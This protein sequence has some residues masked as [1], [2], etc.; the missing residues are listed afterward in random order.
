M[1]VE[2]QESDYA[3][4]VFVP[5]RTSKYNPWGENYLY[6]FQYYT[7]QELMN[8][9]QDGVP[10]VEKKLKALY[11]SVGKLNTLIRELNEQN[12]EINSQI[13]DLQNREKVLTLQCASAQERVASAEGDLDNIDKMSSTDG[14]ILQSNISRWKAEMEQWEN[15]LIRVKAQLETAELK[16]ENNSQK[17]KDYQDGQWEEDDRIYYGKEKLIRDF[18]AEFLPY[19]KEGIWSDNSYVDNDTYF[20]DAQKVLMTSSKPKL[21]LLL[22]W[23]IKSFTL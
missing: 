20:L 7:D 6:N 5:S 23:V 18:E 12:V 15:E 19:I 2:D 22:L 10:L 3:Q 14:E 9:T 17:I 11:T 16:F 4:D 8:V 13:R 21:S 1:Y